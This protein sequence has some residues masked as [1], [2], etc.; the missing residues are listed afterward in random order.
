[1]TSVVFGPALPV[2]VR[3][4]ERPVAPAHRYPTPDD[5]RVA[6]H[7]KARAAGVRRALI[8]SRPGWHRA[9]GTSRLHSP[10]SG[11]RRQ[12]CS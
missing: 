3:R 4:Q 12:L 5:P 11:T 10:Q 1:V 7:G 8:N 9:D 2:A 6:P